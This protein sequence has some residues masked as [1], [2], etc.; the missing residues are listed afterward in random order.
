MAKAARYW[1]SEIG[2]AILIMFMI[3]LAFLPVAGFA[4]VCYAVGR[5]LLSH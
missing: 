3:V 1:L 2:A 5:W 4:Y